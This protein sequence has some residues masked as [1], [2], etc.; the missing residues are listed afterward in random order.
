MSTAGAC[1]RFT[2]HRRS[3]Q[4][5][6]RQ[7]VSQSVSQSD[8]F[9]LC[10]AAALSSAGLDRRSRL[11]R[12]QAGR[13]WA[14][15]RVSRTSA[16]F[17]ANGIFLSLSE[18]CHSKLPMQPS[19]VEHGHAARCAASSTELPRSAQR[20]VLNARC[21]RHTHDTGPIRACAPVR[22]FSASSLSFR[23]HGENKLFIQAGSRLLLPS[24][25]SRG[26]L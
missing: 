14:T 10:S 18:L 9:V 1:R 12:K 6:A 8:G 5:T 23:S 11:L 7:T 26:S 4:R 2:T 13:E 15:D 24:R 3:N 17:K 21:S 22:V 25:P 19:C 16:L 20:M